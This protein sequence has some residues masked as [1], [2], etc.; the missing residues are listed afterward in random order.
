MVK[1]FPTEKVLTV[2]SRH[3]PIGEMLDAQCL[4]T[5]LESKLVT[6][7]DS[8]GLL[9]D[10]A[11]A[12]LSLEAGVCASAPQPISVPASKPQ[13]PSSMRDALKRTFLR[14]CEIRLPASKQALASETF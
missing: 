13:L 14:R 10:V 11:G 5:A 7:V 1:E 3:S 8:D 4:P 12:A 2:F 9:C 6:S